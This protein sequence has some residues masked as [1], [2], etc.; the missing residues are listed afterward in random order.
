MN[1]QRLPAAWA[2][3]HGAKYF[4]STRAVAL[5]MSLFLY[6]CKSFPIYAASQQ[7]SNRQS[8][9]H[10]GCLT[11]GK[12]DEFSNPIGH[13]VFIF[14]YSDSN[15]SADANRSESLLCGLSVL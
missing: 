4:S 15:S 5:V 9:L 11:V 3:Y 12:Y 2:L 8:F 1:A 7:F 6:G 10:F 14:S 13:K